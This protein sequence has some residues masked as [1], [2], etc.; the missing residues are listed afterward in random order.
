MNRWTSFICIR[1]QIVLLRPLCL[2]SSAAPHFVVSNLICF[3][4]CD[5]LLFRQNSINSILR[6]S[7]KDAVSIRSRDRVRPVRTHLVEVSPCSK[8]TCQK[9]PFFKI[10]LRISVS[11]THG[12]LDFSRMKGYS[13]STEISTPVPKTDDKSHF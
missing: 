3:H 7:L 10:T 12:T 2:S 11:R 4:K 6:S 13:Y 1:V 5:C 9:A 8:D